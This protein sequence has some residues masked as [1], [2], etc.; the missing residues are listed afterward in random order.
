LDECAEVVKEMET[1]FVAVRVLRIVKNPG[2]DC[3]FIEEIAEEMLIFSKVLCTVMISAFQFCGGQEPASLLWKRL[4]RSQIMWPTQRMW[5]QILASVTPKCHHLW[6]VVIPQISY[7]GRFFHVME[8]PIEKLHKL[9]RLTSDVVY[10]HIQNYEF[11]EKCKQKQETTARN[12]ALCVDSLTMCKRTA[13]ISFLLKQLQIVKA[14][15]RRPLLWKMS[16]DHSN[17]DWISL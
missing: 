5:E 3:A 6:F 12:I 13:T 14:R 1:E 7:L 16:E 17:L 9:D 4:Q 11:R 8:D 2:P 15:W 10:C